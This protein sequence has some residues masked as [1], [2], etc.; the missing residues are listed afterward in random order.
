M[1]PGRS[2]CRGPAEVVSHRLYRARDAERSGRGAGPARRAPSVSREDVV[3]LFVGDRSDPWVK[4]IAANL[5]P[6]VAVAEGPGLPNRWPAGDV[7]VLHRGTLEA[8]EADRLRSLRAERADG[9]VLLIVGPHVRYQQIHAWTAA[10]LVDEVLTEP[11]AREVLARRLRPDPP[12]RPGRAEGPGRRRQRPAGPGRPGRRRLHRRRLRDRPPPRGA[13]GRRRALGRLGR[14]GPG[15]RLGRSAGGRRPAAG[16]RGPARPGRPRDGRPRPSERR[17]RLPRPAGRP[18]RPHRRPRPP[19]RPRPPADARD[20]SP[21]A[22]TVDAEPPLRSAWQRPYNT[23]CRP[24]PARRHP[25]IPR[26][27]A[28]DAPI[29]RATDRRRPATGRPDP[30]DP[31]GRGVP[32]G[33]GGPQ[34]R[35]ERHHRRR[36][37]LGR[38]ARRRGPEPPRPRPAPGRGRPRR[39]PRRLRRGPGDLRRSI[40]RRLPGLGPL[41]PR[42]EAGG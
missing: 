7:L 17:P 28:S 13:R 42:G 21:R 23:P 38:P 34:E 27:R 30:A 4:A 26:R 5:P 9:R 19:D 6:G 25:T 37:G 39:R 29:P 1:A 41:A 3:G 2:A 20:L 22:A 35:P 36:L 10:G 32:R 12:P 8:A 33:P 11:T 24:R 40:A 31:A 14:A 18:R 15:V 16:G